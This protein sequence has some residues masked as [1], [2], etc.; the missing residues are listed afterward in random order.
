MTFFFDLFAPVRPFL[1]DIPY[2]VFLHIESLIVILW[3]SLSA[4]PDSV[5]ST[6]QKCKSGEGIYDAQ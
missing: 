3:I 5:F 6:R 1:L 2:I 4:D